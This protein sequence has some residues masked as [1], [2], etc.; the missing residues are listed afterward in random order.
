ME[1]RL[2]NNHATGGS[3]H[4]VEYS[5]KKM[6]YESNEEGTRSDPIDEWEYYSV[7]Y[8]EKKIE[9]DE[10][11][12]Q[13]PHLLGQLKKIKQTMLNFQLQ[14]EVQVAQQQQH[15]ESG[16]EENVAS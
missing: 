3:K 11:T 7:Q 12:R 15:K 13:F 16:K 1:A 9:V 10:S 8:A 6:K 14:L 5:Q 2:P 4:N